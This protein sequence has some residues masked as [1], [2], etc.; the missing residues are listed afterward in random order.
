MLCPNC[1]SEI[2]FGNDFASCTNG[3]VFSMKN[4]VYQ[5]V[6]DEHK[7]KLTRYLNA[8]EDFR[9]PYIDTIDPSQFANLPYSDFDTNAFKLKQ[10]DL[11]LIE[12]N[13]PKKKLKAL[14]IGA[15]NGWLSNRLSGFG[16]NTTAV[17]IFTHDLDG[18]GAMKYYPNSWKSIQIDMNRLQ[19]LDDKFDL[20]II[21]RGLNYFDSLSDTIESVKGLLSDGGVLL[22]L[23]LNLFKNVNHIVTNLEKTATEFEKKYGVP[24]KL[25]DY[26]GYLKSSD[27]TI[28]KKNEIKIRFYK[29][30]F[31]QSLLGTF[32]S[33]KP[34]YY[35]GYFINHK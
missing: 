4:G 35:Y 34:K 17:D 21:N 7:D 19:L 16:F 10:I 20:I 27:L 31:F 6:T 15:W 1:I 9:K 24:F 8:F 14:D 29:E 23:G 25:N 33:Y 5:I 12:R 22:I 28:L 26:D 30:L 32:L 11:R 2:E 18:M 13:L 3:H